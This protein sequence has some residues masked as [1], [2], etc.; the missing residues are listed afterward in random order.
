MAIQLEVVRFRDIVPV[1]SV[2][3]FVPNIT[4]LT[5]EVTGEDFSSVESV[6]VNEAQAPNFIVVNKNTLWVELP[7]AAQQR[8][9]TIEVT[10]S[11]FTRTTDSSVI[12]YQIGPKTRAVEGI[13]KLMQ[14]FLKWLL[15]TPG[16]DIFNPDRGGGLQEVA[17][18]L[19][20]N[21]RSSTALA[22]VTRAVSTTANQIRASQLNT[23]RLPSDE[24]LL[25]AQIE[26]VAVNTELMEVHLSI[27][28]LSVAGTQATSNLVL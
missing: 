27:N 7:S 15:Q 12:T 2:N 24:R 28:L 22:A 14:L 21:R 3:G 16:S 11:G 13:L 17:G 9:S 6:Q 18:R 8:I 25:D 20:S 1:K 5:L 4:P 10:S 26:N 23:V 19:S